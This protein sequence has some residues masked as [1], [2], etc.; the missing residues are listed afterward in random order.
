MARL[1]KARIFTKLDIQQGFH[2]IRLDPAHED[3]TTFHTRYGTYKYHVLPFGLTNGSAAFQQFINDTLM[4]YLDEF[5][6]TFVDDI[7]I[8]SE[9][10]AEHEIHVKKVLERLRAAGLQ[11]SIKKCEFH[12]TR[13]KYLGFILTTNGIEADPEKTAIIR[14]WAV[15]TTVWGIQSFLGFCNFY[16]RFIKGYSRIAKA[17]NQLTK[18]EVPFI[19]D[20]KCQ[21]AFEELK[22]RLANA[23]VLYHYQPDLET[24]LETDASDGIVAGVL[25]QRHNDGWHPV[26]Y[27]SKSMTDTEKNYEIHDKEM[28]AIIRALQEWRAELEGLQLR[29]RFN[30]LTDHKALEYFM[31]TKKLNARQARWA[32]F[33]SQFYFLIRYRSG[34]QNMLADALSRHT[35]KNQSD[36]H[37]VQTLLKADSLD[38]PIKAELSFSTHPHRPDSTD[39]VALDHEVHLIDR[40]LQAN[41]KSPSLEEC[42]TALSKDNQNKD[43]NLTLANGLVLWKN[44]LYVPDDQDPELR[45][46]LLDEIHNQ[47]SIAHPGRTKT[48]ELV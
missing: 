36:D 33:L 12:T 25:S 7:L 23:P 44:R 42:R 11:A 28:L 32:E 3:L 40:V 16:R 17:L 35:Q 4:D 22:H 14:N 30:I 45:T 34:K 10:E 24:R 37:R 9:N 8:Y 47:I 19:W 21:Q 46:R 27:Y 48:Q 41:R 29:Q 38:Q 43:R 6:M 2:R 13:T 20:D 5:V 18:K 1:S 15:P 26:A 31:T 39:I